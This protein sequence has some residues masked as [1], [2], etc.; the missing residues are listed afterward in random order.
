LQ[1]L[2]RLCRPF[3]LSF[4]TGLVQLAYQDEHATVAQRSGNC[5]GHGRHSHGAELS[6]ATHHHHH[7]ITKLRLPHIIIIK[8][9]N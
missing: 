4:A 6:A 1:S 9:P 3:A 5:V 8:L 2:C 7:Q